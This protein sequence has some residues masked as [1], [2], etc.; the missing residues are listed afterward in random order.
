MTKIRMGLSSLPD[1]AIINYGIAI[2]DPPSFDARG[3]ANSQRTRELV[4]VTVKDV[5]TESLYEIDIRAIS[6]K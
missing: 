2:L 4:Q 1:D 5:K 6:F 3:E